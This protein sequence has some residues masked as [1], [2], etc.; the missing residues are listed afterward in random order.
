MTF[1]QTSQS[2]LEFPIAVSVGQENSFRYP[3]SEAQLEIWLS[4]E[5]SSEANCAYNEISS[6]NFQGPLNVTALE[7]AIANVIQRHE[8]LRTVVSDNGRE[9]VVFSQMEFSLTKLDFS[10]LTT[11][12]RRA[13]LEFL[14]DDEG[15][16]PFDLNAGPLFRATLQ[17]IDKD[18][19]R[20]TMTAHHIVLDGWSLAVLC[21]DLGHFYDAACAKNPKPLPPVNSY[22]EYAKTMAAH[23]ES[24]AGQRD[25]SFWVKQF[26]D[27]IPVLDLP[28]TNR[29]P[30]LRTY[31]AARYDHLL[32]ADLVERLR[33]VGAKRGCSLFNSMLAAFGGFLSRIS[34][35]H[36]FSLGIP[37][38]GQAALDMPE[39][40]GHCVNTMPLRSHVDTSQPFVELIKARR[41][42][43]LN[44]FEHQKYSYGTLLRKLAAPRD[45]SRPA[46]LNVSFNVDPMIDLASVGFDELEVSLDIE[47]RAF[48]NFEWFVNGVIRADKSIELQV[49]YNLDLF[50]EEAVSFY[51]EGFETFISQ[52]VTDPTIPIR[53]LNL[54]SI[55]QREKAIVSFNQT[56]LDLPNATT[57]HGEFSR[58]AKASP[59]KVAVKFNEAELTYDQ[60]DRRSN[61]IARQLHSQGVSPGDLVGIY[62]DRSER[63]LAYL[64]GILKSGAGYVPLDPTYPMDRLKYMCDHSGL[65]LVITEDSLLDRASE[66][67]KPTLAM[68]QNEQSVR[69]L[70]DADFVCDVTPSEVCY[71]IYTSGSTGKP[72]GVQVPHGSVVNFL[73][74]MRAEPGFRGADESILAVTTLSFDISVLELFLPTVFGGK[75][76]IVDS[77]TAAD[78]AKL[79]SKL[80]KH[81]ISIMQATPATWRLMIQSGW[82]GKADLKILCGGEPMPGD[83]VQPLLDRCSELW[84]MYGPTETTVWSAVYQITDAN[85]PILIGKPIG[86]TQI[87]VLDQFLNEVPLGCEG[88]VYIGGAGVTLGYRNRDDLTQERFVENKYANPF[89]TYVNDRLYKTGDLAKF[90][91]DGNIEFLRRNDKQ[92]KVR[93]FRIEL[94]EIES[95]IQGHADVE[96]S[97]VV[98]RED[99]PGDSRLVAYVIAREQQSVSSTTIRSHVKQA[100]P[101]YMV[102]HHVIVIEKL[103]TTNNGKIDYQALP[104]PQAIQATAESALRLPQTPAEQYLANVWAQALESDEIGLD[105]VFFDIGGHSLLV[106]QIIAAVKEKT[107]ECLSPQEFLICT[108]E[109]MASKIDV[110]GLEA[111]ESKTPRVTTTESTIELPITNSTATEVQ[112][113][114]ANQSVFRKLK[115]FW[116]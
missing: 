107:G 60:L 47:P 103:P 52:V 43:L 104:I 112:T 106:M 1:P 98:V 14:V 41:S 11:E 101:Y 109:Q 31:K 81:Q 3:A 61:Q 15:H 20:L 33:V 24:E 51:F 26:K 50:S 86:N 29:R 72:K 102:P 71:V 54:M 113:T 69:E 105:D 44:A 110:D 39:L 114:D 23:L 74:S 9:M 40:V 48:E 10:N 7:T 83:L 13:K 5:Q 84:N 56:S 67:G 80:D 37:T 116:N 59:D 115:G 70:S 87:Y 76:V 95:A 42:D 64:Y 66:L 6:L 108:L 4:S 18:S 55:P 65:N 46:M 12:E 92:V 85:D 35:T 88:E 17:K 68:D 63:M 45:P 77:M 27:E 62:V 53:D 28:I 8:S 32:S 93:G 34:G 30:A 36:D 111:T 73:Y 91:F 22:R 79:A 89:A 21:Q 90:R 78:G 97:V 58:Q 49:Q 82:A 100:L 57:L 38:A 75:T 25:E 99:T 16:A 19:H 96:Q 2:S 94:G